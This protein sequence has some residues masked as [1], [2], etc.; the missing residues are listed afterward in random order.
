[1]D[2]TEKID[3][4]IPKRVSQTLKNDAELFEIFKK[5]KGNKIMEINLNS[6]LNILIKEFY[7]T[8]ISEYNNY[9]N[10]ISNELDSFDIQNSD[11]LAKTIIN[12][13]IFSS[14]YKKRGTKSERLSFKATEK[15]GAKGV[16]ETID[17]VNEIDDS[18]SQYLGRMLI[19]YSRKPLYERER[20]QKY[21]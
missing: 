20:I 3:I 9:Y 17:E 1:M 18:I 12:K 5:D 6:F 21:L 4:Y 14:D 2:S 8:Y 15:S 19:A 11:A 16:L 13:F 7:I 10:N